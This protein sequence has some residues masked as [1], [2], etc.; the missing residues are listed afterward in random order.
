MSAGWPVTKVL[1]IVP[2]SAIVIVSDVD[3]CRSNCLSGVSV[4]KLWFGGALS[5]EIMEVWI[6]EC[7]SYIPRTSHG[8]LCV[9]CVVRATV[10]TTI[11]VD[12]RWEQI[13]SQIELKQ[14]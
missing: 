2:V 6:S 5:V 12:R 10:V 8:N 13:G 9:L 3:Q 14:A 1:F 7:R 11:D 4:S